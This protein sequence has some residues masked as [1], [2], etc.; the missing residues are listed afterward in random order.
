[1][2]PTQKIKQ[3]GSN[4]LRAFIFCAIEKH[5]IDLWVSTLHSHPF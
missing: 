4:I 2:K 3:R 5:I 1:M